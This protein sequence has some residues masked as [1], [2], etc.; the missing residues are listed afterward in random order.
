MRRWLLLA[1]AIALVPVSAIAQTDPPVQLGAGYEAAYDRFHFFFENDSTFDSPELVPHNFTQTYWGDNQWLLV[2]ARYRAINRAWRSEF[3]MT[4]SRETRGDDVDVFFLASGDVASSGTSGRIDMRSMRVLHE[5][6]T[7]VGGWSIHGAYQ[8]RRDRQVFHT[9]QIKTVTHTRPPS[10]ESFP[11][12]G[13]ETTIA[14][15]HEARIGVGRSWTAGRWSITARLDTAPIA[16]AR[17]TTYLPLKYPGQAIVFAAPV[18]IVAPAVSVS[19]GTSWPI[20]ISFSTLRTFSYSR[21]RQ[22]QRRMWSI[23]FNVAKTL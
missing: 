1:I 18:L 2:S 15:V 10:S 4:P 16:S 14:E 11:I 9:R 8:Y 21:S 5:A 3:A 17:L 22:F 20:G 23:G 7:S 6:T 13:A 12:D 19:R